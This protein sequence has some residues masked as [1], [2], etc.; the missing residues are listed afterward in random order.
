MA[1]I[2]KAQRPPRLTHMI[3]RLILDP[4]IRENALGDLEEQFRLNR[5]SM[6]KLRARWNYRLQLFPV[7]LAF[8]RDSV[9]GGLS[10]LRSYGISAVRHIKKGPLYFLIT[11]SGLILGM[12]CFITA[13]VYSR[14][15]RSFD[16]FHDNKERIFRVYS[17]SAAETTSSQGPRVTT[18]FP[19]AGTLIE[20]YPEVVRAVSIGEFAT[21]DKMLRWE[22]RSV[23]ARGISATPGFFDVFSFRLIHG[24]EAQALASPD[25]IVLSKSLAERIFGS[26]DPLGKAIILENKNSLQITGILEDVPQNSH[27]HFDYILSLH[28]RDDAISRFY[29]GWDYNFVM[30]YIETAPSIDPAFL[31]EKMSSLGKRYLPENKKNT[32]F[33]LQ[34]LTAVHLQPLSSVDPV[35]TGDARQVNLV[36]LIGLL[37]LSIACINA[38]NL[39]MARTSLRVK[40]IGLRKMHGAGRLQLIIQLFVESFFLTLF[41]LSISILLSVSAVPRFSIFFG[42]GISLGILGL[43]FLA[44]FLLATAAAV[45]LGAGL[46]PALV[47]SSP[48][49]AD[50]IGGRQNGKSKRTRL[51]SLLVV[52]QFTSVV[53]FLLLTFVVSHQL[54][55]IQNKP[56]GFAKEHIIVLKTMDEE[57]L[58]KMDEL[59]YALEEH[60]AIHS[61]SLSIPPAGIESTTSAGF[62]GREQEHFPLHKTFVDFNFLEFFE[63]E[64]S[65]GRFFSRKFVSD[66]TQRPVILNETAAKMFG[67]IGIIGKR[68]FLLD[69]WG[70]KHEHEVVGV[71]KDFHFQPLHLPISPLVMELI[72][73]RRSN[74]LCIKTDSADVTKTLASIRE[75]CGRFGD[76]S[77]FEVSFLD[78]TIA[79]MYK[80]EIKLR[81]I[82]RFFSILS[83]TIACLGLIGL[84]THATE[85]RTKEIGIRKV[86]GASVPSIL[87]MLNKEFLQWVLLANLF[88]WPAGYYV[89]EQ[90]LR[91][92]AYRA[93]LPFWI[94]PVVGAISVSIALLTVSS[95]TLLTARKNPVESIRYE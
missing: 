31:E 71:V 24:N 43:P 1:K 56:L 6:G 80:R 13:V 84:A 73:D 66:D 47:L 3:L 69:P 57:V 42:R 11:V 39:F 22:E 95:Q 29:L 49:L 89:M 67:Q 28:K 65:G 91:G 32:V 34:P 12:T 60:S 50:L 83:I 54:K 25:S 8:C 82:V 9:L 70:D 52:G 38:V 26:S 92:F 27:L 86:L 87:H 4:T 48:R 23:R 76:F 18:P 2:T 41:A 77:R 20:E 58:G 62:P 16:R 5:E 37:I 53:S 40:E 88:A 55:F 78:N 81:A 35:D 44:S 51:R 93:S 90:W 46:Y 75:I 30:T 61:V 59:A 68:I 33:G 45:G 10:L 7:L 19:L 64:L 94:F 36:F 85:R 72:P 63:T 17:R 74:I 21:R 15:E 14:Y 79:S